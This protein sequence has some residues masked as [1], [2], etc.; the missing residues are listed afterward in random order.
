MLIQPIEETS[1]PASNPK[2]MVEAKEGAAEQDKTLDD[3]REEVRRALSRRQRA[4]RNI[5]DRAQAHAQSPGRH[6]LTRLLVRGIK[7][8]ADNS[9]NR[10]DKHLESFEAELGTYQTVMG[11]FDKVKREPQGDDLKGPQEERL[12]VAK[13]CLLN[14]R[15]HATAWRE[16]ANIRW[17]YSLEDAQ[18]SAEKLQKMIEAL[19]KRLPSVTEREEW[20]KPAAFVPKRAS[21]TDVEEARIQRDAERN[22]ILQPGQ[23][24]LSPSAARA[25]AH[26][27]VAQDGYSQEWP[28]R[29]PRVAAAGGSRETLGAEHPH[30]ERPTGVPP[31]GATRTRVRSS[32]L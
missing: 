17:N 2:T 28:Q 16:Q 20:H 15:K 6:A 9:M 27:P 5:S 8:L 12:I 3:S 22:W 31:L 21:P 29:R 24:N 4:L 10:G 11:T 18:K 19:E 32:H 26:E 25:S 1:M 30:S 14:A 23:D 13:Q 7:K